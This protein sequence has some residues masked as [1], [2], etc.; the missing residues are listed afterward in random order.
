MLEEA[1]K[2]LEA[3]GIEDPIEG[4]IV[5]ADTGYYSVENLQA[6]E[7]EKV[8]AYVPDQQFR[9][10]DVRFKDSDR[11]RRSTDKRHEKYQSKKRYFDVNDFKMDKSRD[12]LMCPAGHELSIRSRNFIDPKG[13]KFVAYMAPKQACGGCTLRSKCLRN[14][15]TEQR[16]VHIL[17]E[18]PQGT[19]TEKMKE[20]IDTLQERKIYG[21]RL[22]IVEPVF[23]NIRACKKMDRFTLRGKTKVNI[24][25]KLYC[26]VHNIEKILNYGKSFSIA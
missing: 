12:K 2:N 22:G 5:S 15:K 23:G 16:Q 24:Q 17:Y 8:D 7:E 18:K 6:C 14:P 19:V 26:L 10:R 13:Y 1:K 20:K 21:K 11:H 25:W 3:I 9:K 4:K